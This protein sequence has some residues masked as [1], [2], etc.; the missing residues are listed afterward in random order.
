MIL[1]R[2]CILS[3]SLVIAACATEDKHGR[4]SQLDDVKIEIKDVNVKGGLDKAM[5][6]YQKFLKETPE[7]QLTPE[8][9]RRLADL[10]IE[11][12]YGT[13]TDDKQAGTGKNTP[14]K[15]VESA[16]VVVMGKNP[17]SQWI[18]QLRLQT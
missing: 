10:K 16:P 6:G 8:A 7:S 1:K 2:L 15:P 11:K 13:M 18:R 3:L 17:L 5:A 12:E 4:I 14:A 9:I